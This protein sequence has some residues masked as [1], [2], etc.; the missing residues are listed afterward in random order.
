[1]IEQNAAK[2]VRSSQG[3][4]TPHRGFVALAILVSASLAG[5]GTP[6]LGPSPTASPRASATRTPAPADSPTPIPTPSP[7][8]AHAHSV[9]TGSMHEPRKDAMAVLLADGRVLIAGGSPASSVDSEAVTDSAEIY[10]PATGT[11]TL[12]GSMITGRMQATATLLA[13]GRVLIAGGFGCLT[14]ACNPEPPRREEGALKSAEIYDP[15]TGKFTSAG[16]M[17]LSYGTAAGLPDG[18]VLLLGGG[19]VAAFDPETRQFARI[20]SL[21][22]DLYVAA[23]TPIIGG[24][25]LVVGYMGQELGPSHL[26]IA[27]AE[28]F[29]LASGTS[30]LLSVDVPG[31]RLAGPGGEPAVA[32]TD[33]GPLLCFDRYAV[34]Y[35]PATVS[36]TATAP[37]SVSTSWDGAAT[38]PVPSGRFLFTGGWTG[39]PTDPQAATL[40]GLYDPTSGLDVIGSMLH[41]RHGHT[42]TLLPDGSILIAGGYSD[43]EPDPTTSAELLSF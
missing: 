1:M 10:D 33:R 11:F 24:R 42:A 8:A 29:D 13:D 30:R 15:A 28:L 9:A 36:F 37:M 20:G 6:S 27:K 38:T 32:T 43:S 14:K 5:C 25:V 26:G 21:L 34:R 2:G 22:N 39:L 16:Q 18:R 17:A 12:T 41:S 35:D 31:D 3:R 40:V 4:R 23:A 19:E 7:T